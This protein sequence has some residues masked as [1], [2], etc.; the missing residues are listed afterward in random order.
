MKWGARYGADYANRLYASVRRNITGD[1]RFIC[2]TDDANGLIPEI[3]ALP[4]PPIKIPERVQW[5]PWRKI[6]LWQAPLGPLNDEDVLFL[7]LD[8]VLTGPLD[9]FFTYEP[10]K[11]CIIEN[12]TQ[13]GEGIGNTTCYRFRVGEHTEIFENFEKNADAVLGQFRAS[14]QYVS[15]M[16]PGK[17]YWPADW[18]VSFKHSLLPKFPMNWFKTPELPKETKLVAFTGHPDP[19]EARDG[20]WPAPLHKRI[21]K[22]VRPTPWIADHWR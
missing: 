9:D 4:L 8:V 20:V 18:C 6:S 14:Q 5:K 22:H 3:E 21:Y 17:V 7:D 10:G 19:D 15:A 2:F 16:L 11:T 1:L 13:M 12:W